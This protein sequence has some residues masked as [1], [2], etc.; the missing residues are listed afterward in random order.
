MNYKKLANFALFV[1]G[2]WTALLYGNAMALIALFLVLAL[3]FVMWRDVRDIFII[4]GFIFCGFAIEWGFMASGVQDYHSN[5]PP[6]WAICIWAMLATTMRY[7]LSW[8]ISK[9]GYAA[10]TGLLVAPVFYFNSVHFGPAGWGRPVWQ[11]LLSIAL[12][13]S[14]LAAF[15]SSVLVPLVEQMESAESSAT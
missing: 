8:L 2:W 13:W 7:S 5:L 4:L 10:L 1:A 11:C 3:H 6:A 15:L 9:P 12:V 14:L